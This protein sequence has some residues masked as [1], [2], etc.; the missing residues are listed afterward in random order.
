[1]YHTIGIIVFILIVDIQGSL[2]NTQCKRTR[3]WNGYQF[4]CPKNHTIYIKHH[5]IEDGFHKLSSTIFGCQ[6]TDALYCGAKLPINQTL[7]QNNSAFSSAVRDCNGKI[8]CHVSTQYFKDVE[9]GLRK[10]CSQSH[11][12]DLNEAKF[13]QSID[14]ECIQDYQVID[15]CTNRKYSR[16]P[17]V[18]LRLSGDRE[19]CSCDVIGNISPVH[20]LQTNMVEISIYNESMPFYEHNHPSVSLYGVEVQVITKK[21]LIRTKGKSASSYILI[22]VLAVPTQLTSAVT[23]QKGEQRL[24]HSSTSQYVKVMGF[25]KSLNASATATQAS[26]N[27]GNHQRLLNDKALFSSLF[28]FLGGVVL[29]VIFFLLLSVIQRRK[30]RDLLLAILHKLEESDQS[31]QEEQHSKT[32]ETSHIQST[33]SKKNYQEIPLQFL[34]CPKTKHLSNPVYESSSQENVS[35]EE[36]HVELSMAGS[37]DVQSGRFLLESDN[38]IYE[39]QK[40]F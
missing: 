18:Y 25:D 9:A 31:V 34:N 30:D 35:S 28:L 27:N 37:M 32:T 38:G 8:Q 22:K 10:S 2:Q 15:M 19:N 17:H 36:Q 1:M 3:D 23:Q 6:E 21:L 24:T 12:S 29:L 20:I 11:Q 39:L 14:Y 40:R 26:T 16:S 4:Q 33:E 7:G 5:I 13:R